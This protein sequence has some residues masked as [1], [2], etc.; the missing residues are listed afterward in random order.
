MKLI[1]KIPKLQ[2]K[3]NR[4]S[5]FN[6][7]EKRVDLSRRI[8]RKNKSSNNTNFM[9]FFFIQLHVMISAASVAAI[10][11]TTFPLFFFIIQQVVWLVV[12][13][14]MGAHCCHRFHFLNKNTHK[15]TQLREFS[16]AWLGI[17]QI[18]YT[19][20]TAVRLRI[21][22]SFGRKIHSWHVW[23]ANSWILYSGPTMSSLF[24]TNPTL[25]LFKTKY[26]LFSGY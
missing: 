6:K 14:A 8:M 7:K 19:L 26:Y 11:T 15:Q 4:S 22:R 24:F 1:V 12:S 20:K 10:T 18:C 16:K 25:K 3:W 9:V 21:T 5:R 17:N 2:R 13:T 23:S